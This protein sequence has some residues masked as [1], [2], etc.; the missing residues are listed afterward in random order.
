M[1]AQIGIIFYLCF[2][3]LYIFCPYFTLATQ[4]NLTS[5]HE[6]ISKNN[7]LLLIETLP[8]GSYKHVSKRKLSHSS[9]REP[10]FDIEEDHSYQA[11]LRDTK[12]EML[13]K[14]N[15]APMARKSMK[16][17]NGIGVTSKSDISL[18]GN[19]RNWESLRLSN[20]LI[21]TDVEGGIHALNRK[22]GEVLWS[23][24][25]SNFSPLIQLSQPL[26]V[27][28]E[29]LIIEP[30]GDGHMYYFNAFQGL[31]KLPVSIK[32]LILASPMSFKAKIIVDNAGA[33]VEDTKLYTGSRATA[34][35]T[36]DILTGDVVSAYGPG[37]ENKMYRDL[38]LNCVNSTT[39]NYCQNLLVIG[40]TIYELGIH[41]KDGTVYNLTYASW[42]HN[43]LD[44]C[45]A[46]QNDISSD[47]IYIAPFRDKSLLAIDYYFKMA[48]WVSPNFPGIV[49][50]VF[51][52]F[53]DDSTNEMI[54]LP[55]PLKS[56]KHHENDVQVYLDQTKNQ[57]WFAMSSEYFPA[58]VDSAPTSKY[59][60]SETWRQPHIFDDKK[61]FKLSVTGLH[62]LGDVKFEGVLNNDQYFNYNL[63]STSPI[64][65]IEIEQ[66]D[67]LPSVLNSMNTN[68][69]KDIEKYMTPEEIFAYKVQIQE[70]VARELLSKNKNSITSIIARF[71][72]RIVESGL[73]LI[74]SLM[75]I[76]LLSKFKIILPLH[77]ILEKSGVIPKQQLITKQVEINDM[78]GEYN[79]N[80]D[81]KDP[82]I[83]CVDR[84][85]GLGILKDHT[86]SQQSKEEILLN[87]K[88]KRK[89]GNRGGK[90][91]KRKINIVDTVNESQNE[92]QET[93]LKHLTISDDVLGY[94]SSGTVVFRGNFQNRSVAV[95]RM[96]IDFYDIA[97]HEIK[98]LSES[99][100]HPNVVRYYCSEVSQKFLYIAVE[101]CTASLEEIIELKRDPV[102]FLE[103]QRQADPIN[104]LRQIVFGVSHLHSMKIV[105]RDIKPQNILIAPQKRYGDSFSNDK[106]SIR[107]LISDFGLC[108]K[109]EPDESFFKTNIANASG[110]SGWRAPELL[111]GRSSIENS[112]D[113]ESSTSFNNLTNKS[114]DVLMYD[115]FTKKRLTRAIDIFSL[116]CVFYYVL[117]KGKHPFGD[118]YLREGN[119][120]KDAYILDELHNTLEDQSLIVEA[121]DLISQM[122]SHDPI[123][124][125]TA[126][127]ILAHPFFWGIS[128]KL[129]FLLKVS[130]RFE[131]ERR[132]PP[133][134]LLLKLEA[135]SRNVIID[136]DWT[137]KF[138]Q[139]FM[140][141]LGKYRK[142]HGNKLIDLLRSFR[143]KYHHFMDLPAEL[144]EDIGPFPNGFYN[145]FVRKFPNLLMEVYHLVD[146]NLKQDQMLHEFFTIPKSGHIS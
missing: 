146:E 83:E 34:V 17:I 58:L 60:L 6:L 88:K 9:Y 42:Q 98:L 29:T 75:V 61:L 107:V 92:E 86:D 125:P 137:L 51:D 93:S 62:N 68:P 103:I 53:I 122:I 25:D 87:E 49:N 54:L 104:I 84:K 1:R 4:F 31:Q 21:V 90:K 91:N 76:T 55:H 141:N 5:D 28:H 36:M 89:R 123:K 2:F 70:K 101:L 46:M 47:G 67:N 99:D 33:T 23:K 30:Y 112:I 105:H 12:P 120:I 117:S 100:D 20:I 56:F 63:L 85:D 79:N 108:K 15:T 115:P 142:Y 45:L 128:R 126:L 44:S 24:N 74:F 96:L 71:I 139:M 7:S 52:I 129:D 143:N 119:I 109:L 41:S 145:Y 57:I 22:N 82:I 37:T 35:Y 78:G 138:N 114:N 127:Q 26:N 134:P 10:Q 66:S 121:K 8:H 136:G 133:S 32:Q 116:G 113:N 64:E 80:N 110:T 81:S 72:Y 95:K 97:S 94:G 3:Y 135:I 48:K 18:I 77:V 14:W 130:D 59:V 111:K 144:T 73:I 140:D 40:K 50:N 131:I 38:E 39:K 11:H 65:L 16:A 102:S 106:S 27:T 19:Y 132:E 69:I 43:S 13:V 124:R 118:R